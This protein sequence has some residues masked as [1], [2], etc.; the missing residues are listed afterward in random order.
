VIAAQAREPGGGL[1]V[2]LGVQLRESNFDHFVSGPIPPASDVFM[3]GSPSGY[4]AAWCLGLS[5]GH[6]SSAASLARVKFAMSL[7]EPSGKRIRHMAG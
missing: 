3:S 2:L 4:D 5:A 7:C 1:I 6:G